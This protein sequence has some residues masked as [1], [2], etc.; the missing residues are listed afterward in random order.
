LPIDVDGRPTEDF[1]YDLG[2][3]SAGQHH[4]DGEQALTLSRIRHKYSDFFRMDNQ[5][6]V[7]CALK[8]KITTPAIITK[9]PQ[10]ISAL[11]GSVVTDL[12]P[13]QLA[14]LACLAPKLESEDLL[15]TG[16]PQEILSSERVYSPELKDE[17]SALEADT[18]V[19]QDFAD[20]FTNGSWPDVPD[21]PFCP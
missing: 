11:Q 21:E 13:Q 12:T 10:F 16:L 6:R 18:Q 20:R 3:Y 9:I 17:T 14:Q 8:D 7:I 5:S 4:L 15:F 19:I 1:P 2:Y